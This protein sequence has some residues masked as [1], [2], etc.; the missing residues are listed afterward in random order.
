[1]KLLPGNLHKRFLTFIGGDKLSYLP[2]VA[3][4]LVERSVV[5]VRDL[6]RL[7]H[8]DRLLLVQVFPLVR[9]LIT[10]K[11]DVKGFM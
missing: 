5:V 1:M 10:K 3:E 2:V 6:L 8:P 11:K 7:P 9:D 4:G